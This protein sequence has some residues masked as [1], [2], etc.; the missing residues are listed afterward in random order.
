MVEEFLSVMLMDRQILL[1]KKCILDKFYMY[2]CII[3]GGLF[4][5]II[6]YFYNKYELR[7]F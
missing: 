1:L 7:M 2:I 6:E 3:K 5:E 4:R